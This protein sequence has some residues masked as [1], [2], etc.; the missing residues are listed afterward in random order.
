MPINRGG[1]IMKNAYGMIAAALTAGFCFL[2]LHALPQANAQ[3]AGWVTLFD[4][5]SIDNWDQVG[6]SNWHVADGAI[7]ADKMTDPKIAGYL[8]SKQSYK[9]FVV[10]V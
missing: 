6:G 4:G 3:E 8:V 5:K 10:R 7:V 9:N 2:A 1:L